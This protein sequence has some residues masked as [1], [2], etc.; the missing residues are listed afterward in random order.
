LEFFFI[1]DQVK[2]FCSRFTQGLPLFDDP[3]TLKEDAEL[4]GNLGKGAKN[5]VL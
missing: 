4:K 3:F 5:F 2:P 1:G